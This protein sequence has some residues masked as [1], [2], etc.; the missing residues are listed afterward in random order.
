M[1]TRTRS[2]SFAFVTC[3]LQAVTSINENYGL[4]RRKRELATPRK[5]TRQV[6]LTSQP[7]G[8]GRMLPD[9]SC[10]PRSGV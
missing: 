6:R 8:Q 10:N 4:V 3:L 5:K 9:R 7:P 1:L 2:S